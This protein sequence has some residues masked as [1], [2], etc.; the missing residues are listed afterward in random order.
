MICPLKAGDFSLR[1]FFQ[2]IALCA[3]S[4][5]LFWLVALKKEVSPSIQWKWYVNSTH[6]LFLGKEMFYKEWI[7]NTMIY[8]NR[9]KFRITNLCHYSEIRSWCSTKCSRKMLQNFLYFMCKN[10]HVIF[11][12]FDLVQ[13]YIF[14][15]WM[16]T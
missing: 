2:H 16:S 5:H 10:T 6:Q 12:L 1:V 13:L 4:S 15:F 7:D 11:F 8:V 3:F 14:T 9:M